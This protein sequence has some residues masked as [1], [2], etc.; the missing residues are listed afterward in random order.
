MKRSTHLLCMALLLCIPLLGLSAGGTSEETTGPHGTITLYTS[1]PQPIVDRLQAEFSESYPQITLDVFRSGTS[2]V[3]TKLMTEKEAGSIMA[4]LLWVAEPSTYE[5]LDEQGLL[6]QFTPKEASA[7]SESM[8][9]PQG[10]YYA[11]RQINMVIAYN[12]QK[13][14]NPPTSWKDLIE[15]DYG[16]MG[17]PTPLRSGAALASVSTIVDTYGWDYFE[18]FKAKGGIQVKSNS[19]SRD[20]V[21]TGELDVGVLLDYM[22][23]PLKAKGSPIEYVWP[24]EGTVFIP[25]PIAILK[26]SKNY[27]ASRLFVDYILSPEGQQVVVEVGDFYPVREDV[28]PPAG[29]PDLGSVPCMD[30][31]W[32]SVKDSTDTIYARWSEIFG[33]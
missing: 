18:A 27:E 19:T 23:R 3:I 4:D 16:K 12:P 31:D 14:K 25:S 8:K 10:C 24:E 17:F 20:M 1:V 15:G 32:V 2:A 28:A 13:V 26:N 29:A 33:E 6:Y 30:T 21:V 11:A 7:L 22:V 9:D 5:L